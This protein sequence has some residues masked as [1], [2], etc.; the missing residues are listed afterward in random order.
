MNTTINP[1]EYGIAQPYP[2]VGT[3]C[4]RSAQ[5]PCFHYLCNQPC[6]RIPYDK[7]N[8]SRIQKK[9]PH[10][11]FSHRNIATRPTNQKISYKARQ[12]KAIEDF[13]LKIYRLR[14]AFFKF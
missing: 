13:Y 11:D 5:K 1:G 10:K 6:I 8:R 7:A 4:I 12:T 3:L 2:I 9:N 14:A